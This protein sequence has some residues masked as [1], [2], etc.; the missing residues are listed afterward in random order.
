[1]DMDCTVRALTIED[2]PILWTMLMYAAHETSLASVQ[3]QPMLAR[4]AERWGRIGDIGAVAILDKNAIAAAWLRLWTDDDRGFGYID[5][6]IP[7]LA[8]AVLPEY[9]GNGVGSRLLKQVLELSQGLFPAVSLSVR[10]DNPV[11]NLYQ[12]VGFAKV[13]DSETVN[14]V[15]DIS[16]NMVYR[17]IKKS[18]I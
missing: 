15:G 13:E 1:M 12:R 6:A 14:R 11:V 9:R 10:A 2:E 8:I 7:E 16:F 3:S 17:H 4:Y 18:N 5:R